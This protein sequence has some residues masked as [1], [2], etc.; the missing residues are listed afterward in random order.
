MHKMR[1]AGIGGQAAS[2]VKAYPESTSAPNEGFPLVS[3]TPFLP[4]LA[5]FLKCNLAHSGK[6]SGTGFHADLDI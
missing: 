4:P 5:S 3:N 6:M 2:L 1:A